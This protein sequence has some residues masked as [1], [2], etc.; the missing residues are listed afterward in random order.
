M[1]QGPSVVQTSFRQRWDG[2]AILRVDIALCD[3]RYKSPRGKY[4]LLESANDTDCSSY[5]FFGLSWS[6]VHGLLIP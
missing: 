1:L 6:V 2:R 5:T 3:G 4:M